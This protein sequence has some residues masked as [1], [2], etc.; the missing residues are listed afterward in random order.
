MRYILT[1]ACMVIFLISCE[2]ENESKYNDNNQQTID[3]TISIDTILPKQIAAFP[4]EKDFRDQSGNGFP[5]AFSGELN[6]KT[7]KSPA[8]ALAVDI[9]DYLQFLL[10]KS[11]TISFTC[12]MKSDKA[13]DMNGASL[14]DFNEKAKIELDVVSGATHISLNDVTQAD[15]LNTYKSW[16]FVYVELVK[17][18]TSVKLIIKN[19]ESST[20]QTFTYTIPFSE[21]LS[22]GDMIRIGSSFGKKDGFK[23]AF[24]NLKIFA[25]TL[26]SDEVEFL[27]KHQ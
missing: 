1:A 19:K 15:A 18:S 8:F 25:R 20:A 12:F 17:N 16:L 4:F 7:S 13:V 26:S 5:L 14:F 2:S 24:D 6:Y 21:P 22:T 10:P 23:G 11:D 27:Y 3:D 9:T